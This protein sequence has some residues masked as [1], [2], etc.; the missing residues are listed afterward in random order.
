MPT[1]VWHNARCWISLGKIK[2]RSQ[3]TESRPTSAQCE[4]MVYLWAKLGC[5]FRDQF[6]GT[7]LVAQWLRICLVMQGT[8]SSIPGLGTKIPPTAKPLSLHTPTRESMHGNKWS[9]KPQL[10]PDAAKYINKKI[11]NKTKP[12]LGLLQSLDLPQSC[13]EPGHHHMSSEGFLPG[14]GARQRQQNQGTKWGGQGNDEWHY[15]PWRRS[16]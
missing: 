3:D 9:R 15:K 13:Y 14:P 12:V 8:M 11:F 5:S 10:R 1:C 7:S 4:H 2:E 16:L 6:W